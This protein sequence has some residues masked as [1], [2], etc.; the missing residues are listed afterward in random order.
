VIDLTSPCFLQS[1]VLMDCK[2]PRL[3][4]SITTL[5]ILDMDSR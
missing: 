4:V 3:S 1:A 2:V 5:H